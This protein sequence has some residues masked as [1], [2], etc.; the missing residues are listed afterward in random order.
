MR[1]YG[2]QVDKWD[3]FQ[4]DLQDFFSLFY[5]LISIYFLRNETII[6]RSALSFGHSDPDPSSVIYQRISCSLK[7]QKCMSF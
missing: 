1:K 7:F 5:I 3:Y 2:I 4:N 6:G